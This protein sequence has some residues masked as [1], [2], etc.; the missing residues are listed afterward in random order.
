M[1]VKSESE[2]VQLCPSLCDPTDCSL[3]G[4]SIHGIFQARV[5][6]WVTIAFSIF[7]NIIWKT[8]KNF[9]ANSTTPHSLGVDCAQWL[10]F[11]GYSVKRG[12]IEL[13]FS[14]ETWQA[15]SQSEDQSQYHQWQVVL[16]ALTLDT[17]WENFTLF[18]W[19]SSPALITPS[20]HEKTKTTKKKSD[21]SRLRDILF[22][23]YFPKLSKSSKSE[24]EKWSQSKGVMWFNNILKVTK[25]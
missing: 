25:L 14:G 12:K 4:F 8:W 13:L 24:S 11:K 16:V 22:D 7:H 10:P 20:N 19:S 6:E 15:L 5:L 2:V 3:P 17:M 9:L 23:Q 1:K 18:L 21:Q